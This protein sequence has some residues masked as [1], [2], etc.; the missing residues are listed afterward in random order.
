MDLRS[1]PSAAG[2]ALIALGALAPACITTVQV[3]PPGLNDRE[4][5][6]AQV[7]RAWLVNAGPGP[8]LGSVV[9]LQSMGAGERFFY[10][11]RNIYSQDLGLVDSLGRAYRHRPHQDEPDLL[12]SG[13]VAE[14][15]ARILELDGPV[16]LLEIS[17][18]DLE[19]RLKQE[20]DR[21]AAS[22]RSTGP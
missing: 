17:L 8:V 13:T 22:R 15:V 3:Q 11:V 14:G 9:R 12:G 4:V 21:V 10:A 20:L 18:G 16:E 5:P 6:T 19:A 7:Q 2:L 1:A